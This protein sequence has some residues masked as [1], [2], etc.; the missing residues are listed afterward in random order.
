M[1]IRDSDRSERQRTYNFP[2]NRL[3]DHRVNLTLHSLDRVMEGDLGAVLD[4]LK[5]KD[6]QERMAEFGGGAA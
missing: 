6:R 2:Q 5:L 4:A 3:T 1:C